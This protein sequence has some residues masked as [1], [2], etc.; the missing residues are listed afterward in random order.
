MRLLPNISASIRK[1][2]TIMSFQLESIQDI[3]Q[4]Q[5][6]ASRHIVLTG[7]TDGTICVH[8]K[9]DLLVSVLVEQAQ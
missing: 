2:A 5:Y 8:T 6:K 9:P 1:P 3:L 7:G 4:H